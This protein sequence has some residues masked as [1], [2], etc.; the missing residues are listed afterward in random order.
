MN[1][2][3]KEI[4]WS[5]HQL[6]LTNQRAIY[7]PLHE[8]LILSDLHIGKAAHFRKNG[9]PIPT[10]I[11]QQDLNKL[12]YLIQYFKAKKVIIVGD[13][14][15]ANEN[16]EVADISKL[17]MKYSD[18]EF[19]LIQGNHDRIAE[20]KIK[21]W[22]F[23]A[24]DVQMVVDTIKFVHEPDNSFHKQIVGH[25]HPGVSL[26]LPTNKNL[27]LPAFVVSP[28]QIILP[29]FSEFTGL[30]TKLKIP[31]SIYYAIYENGII[32]V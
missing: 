17:L 30:D 19:I 27:R 24:V 7:W 23:A 4:T 28:S 13:L 25:I 10:Q 18:V 15:H 16:I 9:I 20:K 5:S 22:G 11:H 8:S 3:E 32:Q 6:I 21:S 26:R 29:A 2:V 12:T 31:D 14:V 1:I